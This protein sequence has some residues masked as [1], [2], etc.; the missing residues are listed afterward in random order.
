MPSRMVV[1][2]RLVTGGGVTSGLDVALYLVVRELGPRISHA[3]EK[4]FEYER[5][6]TVWTDAGLLPVQT[7]QQRDPE[8][9]AL[10]GAPPEAEEGA[11]AS[12]F[13][14][15]WDLAISTPVGSSPKTECFTALSR[16]AA[17]GPI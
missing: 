12:V 10:D 1:D 13:D 5:K 15:T 9:A 4:R 6:G 7:R 8:E 14:G 2:G 16:K 17:N 11:A 3:V